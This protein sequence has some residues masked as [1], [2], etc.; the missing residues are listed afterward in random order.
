MRA[1]TTKR[2]P[3]HLHPDFLHVRP[4]YLPRREDQP[5]V[6]AQPRRPLRVVDVSALLVLD[7][8]LPVDRHHLHP[9]P[10]PA[11]RHNRPPVRR[12]PHVRGR[13]IAL[14]P[15][16]ALPVHLHPAH[17]PRIVQKRL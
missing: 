1:H 4:K 14:P 3:L 8:L 10:P 6:V 9:P 16:P 17:R 5:P 7:D 15:A 2:V 12:H 13:P 11:P